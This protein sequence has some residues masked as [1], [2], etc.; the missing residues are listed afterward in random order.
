METKIQTFL[1][2]DLGN[3]QKLLSLLMETHIVEDILC[4]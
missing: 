2:N 3:R 1:N 4:D